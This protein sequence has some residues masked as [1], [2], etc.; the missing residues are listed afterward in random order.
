M[1][2]QPNKQ[3]IQQIQA[4]TGLKPTHFADLIR[5]AQLVYDPGGGVSGKI[6][7]VDW[8]DF[9]I[10]EPVA[11]NLCFLGRKYRYESPQVDIDLVWED[12]TPATRSWL[13]ANR[14]EL[15]RIEEAFPALDED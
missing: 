13:I 15:W 6:L 7:R 12:L 11:E 3:K 5:V 10:P 9:E 14:S 2:N 8:M 4:I 1:N